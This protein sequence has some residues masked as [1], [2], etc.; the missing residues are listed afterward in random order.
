MIIWTRPVVSRGHRQERHSSLYFQ[1]RQ[2]GCNLG[3]VGLEPERHA[4]Q[5]TPQADITPK[6]S[7]AKRTI[8]M[9]AM[10]GPESAVPGHASSPACG[11]PMGA[12]VIRSSPFSDLH[13][14]RSDRV[15]KIYGQ[16]RI[17]SLVDALLPIVD[18]A[19]SPP[20]ARRGVFTM[21][22]VH[23]D[24]SSLI[25]AAR[26]GDAA[27][28]AA[29]LAQ[30]RLDAKRYARTHCHF[31]DLEDAVQEAL[32]AIVNR[33]GQLKS[34]DAFPAWLATTVKR[35]C[36]RLHLQQQRL[37]PITDT[38]TQD[39]MSQTLATELKVDLLAALESLP[40]HYL[41]VVL[42]RDFEERSIKE[43]AHEVGEPV[44]TIKSRLHR[45]RTMLREYLSE[46]DQ[47]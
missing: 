7:T 25:E 44:P 32:M 34:L 14:N 38:G 4:S 29:L 33:L 1:Q 41:E 12:P 28:L 16:R 19:T 21:Q 2:A 42:L 30:S 26:A 23:G 36:S 10:H 9:H 3:H 47:P 39:E 31:S 18:A 11:L 46:E 35:E 37:T 15:L 20:R 45:A 43:I 27:A 5:T 40:P 8:P 24:R 17:K 13:E 22:Q 6:W